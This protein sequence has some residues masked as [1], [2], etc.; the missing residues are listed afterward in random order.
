AAGYLLS[1]TQVGQVPPVN[2]PVYGRRPETLAELPVFES[3][4]SPATAAPEAAPGLALAPGATPAPPAPGLAASAPTPPITAE[5]AAYNQRQ[6]DRDDRA[7][8]SREDAFDRQRAADKTRGLGMLSPQERKARQRED[9]ARE[10][11]LGR[12][13]AKDIAE[14]QFVT[15]P[16]GEETIRQAG[17]NTIMGTQQEGELAT[18]QAKQAGAEA[19]AR[20]NRAAQTLASQQ[21]PPAERMKAAGELMQS[22]ARQIADMRKQI[23][24]ID[25]LPPLSRDVEPEI[26]TKTNEDLANRKKAISR[27]IATLEKERREYEAAYSQLSGLSAPGLGPSAGGQQGGQASD[28]DIT[29]AFGQLSAA[30]MAEVKKRLASGWT[31]EQLKAAQQG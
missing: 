10:R 19:I 24:E 27:Q 25:L 26:A 20:E 31:L 28:A 12:D 13:A 2:D 14:M 4:R 29:A 5:Q 8:I 15:G 3:S 7:A 11:G 23:Q 17:L 30:D 21:V 18:E 1:P 9:M 22:R 16:Q 6:Q